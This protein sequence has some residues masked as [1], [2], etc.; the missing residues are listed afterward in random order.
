MPGEPAN[1]TGV[2]G[3]RFAVYC[4]VNGPALLPVIVTGRF[5]VC[6]EQIIWVPDNTA[7]ILEALMIST[8]DGPPAQP[9]PEQFITVL[10]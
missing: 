5:A 4:A 3:T 2:W 8:F 10:K 1:T 9:F 6:P 7:D